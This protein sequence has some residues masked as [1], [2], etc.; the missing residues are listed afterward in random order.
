MLSAGAV[1]QNQNLHTM[2]STWRAQLQ[3]NQVVMNFKL[4]SHSLNFPFPVQITVVVAEA[5]LELIM[6][7]DKKNHV[8]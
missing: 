6:T 4:V 8:L 2:S 1:S 3:I 5:I 7:Q